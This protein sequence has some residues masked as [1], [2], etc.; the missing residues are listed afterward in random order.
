[1]LR[2]GAGDATTHDVL[3][4][5]VAGLLERRGLRG[6]RISPRSSVISIWFGHELGLMVYVPEI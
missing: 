1:V 5:L 3:E 6:A 4:Q 2:I